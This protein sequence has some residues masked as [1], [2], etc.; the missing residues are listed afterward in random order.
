MNP[1]MDPGM[2]SPTAPRRRRSG[3]RLLRARVR[4]VDILPIMPS[5]GPHAVNVPDSPEQLP[6]QLWL[7]HVPEVG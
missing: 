7:C 1:G 6:R 4:L 3:S 5:Y 2:D